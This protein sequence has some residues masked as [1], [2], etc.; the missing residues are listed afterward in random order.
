MKIMPCPLN[1]PRNITEFVYGGRV[2]EAIDPARVDDA[3]W[4]AHLFHHPHPGG[5]VREWWCHLASGFWF[6]AE[7]DVTTDDILR[8]YPPGPDAKPDVKAD[9]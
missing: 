7:R 5:P 1:G 6:I 8:T 3:A 2:A 4:A 9:P